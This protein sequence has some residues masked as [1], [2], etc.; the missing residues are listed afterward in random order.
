MQWVVRVAARAKL[1][2]VVA[3]ALGVRFAA[4]GVTYIGRDTG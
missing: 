1:A 3:A 4:V 2:L